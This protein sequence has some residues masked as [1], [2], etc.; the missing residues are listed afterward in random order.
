MFST[1][2][3]TS[4]KSLMLS[5]KN[6]L[7]QKTLFLIISLCYSCEMWV[8]GYKTFPF[9][10]ALIWQITHYSVCTERY[11]TISWKF[12]AYIL[13]AHINYWIIRNYIPSRLPSSDIRRMRVFHAHLSNSSIIKNNLGI[14]TNRIP[15]SGDESNNQGCD[16]SCA[17]CCCLGYWLFWWRRRIRVYERV[18]DWGGTHSCGADYGRLRV[19]YPCWSGGLTRLFF[20]ALYIHHIIPIN[21]IIWKSNLDWN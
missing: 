1:H 4:V 14:S 3:L 17:S 20:L 11:Q 19:Q 5:H 13:H 16:Y 18:C 12:K 2:L 9:L 6:K 8:F 7:F 21:E 15:I 10:Y